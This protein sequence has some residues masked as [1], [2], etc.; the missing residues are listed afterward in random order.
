MG[1]RI[2]VL[3]LIS[4]SHP[5]EYFRLIARYTDHARFAIKVGSLGRAG[6][7]QR[8]LEEISI[9]TFALGAEHR[10]EYPRVVMQLAWSLRRERIDVLH[11]HLFE[12][13]VVGLLAARLAGVKLRVFTGHH[14]H[15]VP[16][17]DWRLLLEVDRFVAQRLAN[18]VVAPS[19]QMRAIFLESYGLDAA[20]VVVI[21][22]GL[23]LERFDPGRADPEAVRRELGLEGKLILGAI[24]KPHWVK[25][26]DAL[27]RG[28]EPIATS[29]QDAHLLI[30]GVG[31]L[32]SL[33]ATIQD[34]GLSDRITL[35]E[36]R[37][38]VPQVLAALDL[39]VHPALA[40]SFGFSIL[41]AMAMARPVIVTPVGIAPDIVEDDVS[42]FVIKGAD[43]D[44]LRDA[45]LRALASRDRWAALAMEA[46]RRALQFPADRWVRAYEDLY[47]ARLG[48]S[49]V[50]SSP[51]I[52]PLPREPRSEAYG[53]Q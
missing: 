1:R 13:S 17:Y 10:R 31:D 18:V 39:Y 37:N 40:E 32:P 51:S 26:L 22:H 23:D 5:T 50:G 41:E 21:E 35:L 25:N 4:E 29:R 34:L 53:K 33:Q 6:G 47:L 2:R 8:G 3:H 15:E 19:R 16:L 45:M 14:S 46:R 12:A 20:E 52:G 44:A 48:G 9:P 27:V 24:S 7:L 43:R 38:D 30:L 11:A 49:L 28:F 36:R 42:G